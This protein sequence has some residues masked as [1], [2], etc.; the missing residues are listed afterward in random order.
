MARTKLAPQR[1]GGRRPAPS[2]D[3]SQPRRRRPHRHRPGVMALR[4]IRKYQRSTDVLIPKLAFARLVREVCEEHFTVPG[5]AWRF[6]AS[7]L[8]AIQE[9]TEAYLT[10]LFEDANVCALHCK[11]VT[12]MV[13]D[14]QL[15]R[16]LRGDDRYAL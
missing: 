5:Q 3:G 13:K 11:R 1:V 12:I 2:P 7:A 8:L 16:R 10:N 15:A 4:E 9:A 6:Q 14:I